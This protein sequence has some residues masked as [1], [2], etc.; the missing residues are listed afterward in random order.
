MT[1]MATP[2]DRS[3]VVLPFPPSRKVAV[4]PVPG[5]LPLTQFPE[6]VQIADVLPDQ[7]SL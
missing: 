5:K 3:I 7:V 4:W 2:V 6:S 1:P